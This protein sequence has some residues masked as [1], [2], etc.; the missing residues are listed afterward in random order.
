MVHVRSQLLLALS[1]FALCVVAYPVALLAFAQLVPGSARGGL[2]SVDGKAVGSALIA[3]EFKDAKYFHARPSAASY[4]GAA[5]SGSNLAA[6]NPKLRERVTEALN[7][8]Y[9]QQANVPADAVTAS[10]SGLDPHVTL[11]NARLQLP[12][13][14]A[15]RNLPVNAVDA[16]LARHSFTPLLGLAGEPLVNVLEVNLELDRRGER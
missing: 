8:D 5:S 11:A 7:A 12:R 2:V 14:A 3:Q 6:S 13:V 10:G 9:A 16:A 1:L 4:N 15:A